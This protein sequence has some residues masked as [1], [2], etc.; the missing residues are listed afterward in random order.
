[1]DFKFPKSK[2]YVQCDSMNRILAIDGGYSIDNIKNLSGWVLIDEG[3]GDRCNLCQNNYLPKPVMDE[4]GIYRYKYV[5]G[6]II[7]RTQAEM[8]ADWHEPEA[9][10]TQAD[11]IEA[12]VLYTALMTDTLLEV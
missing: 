5:N 8:D 11:R 7:E 12:Q 1:M 10:A 9:V 6:Q 4:R 3:I 2:V